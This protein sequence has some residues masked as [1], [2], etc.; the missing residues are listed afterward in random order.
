MHQPSRAEIDPTMPPVFPGFVELYELGQHS[1]SL[2]PCSGETHL[3]PYHQGRGRGGWNASLKSKCYPSSFA[4]G[5]TTSTSGLV[6]KEDILISC[7]VFDI[8]T[9]LATALRAFRGSQPD[10]RLRWV[11]AICYPRENTAETAAQL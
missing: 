6:A 4:F 11:K 9:T 7:H 2:G 8:R 5:E 1:L 3:S 10:K